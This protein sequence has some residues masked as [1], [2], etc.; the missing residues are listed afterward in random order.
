MKDL[1]YS[2]ASYTRAHSLKS[3]HTHIYRHTYTYTHI[4]IH[5]HIH[6]HTHIHTYTHTHSKTHIHTHAHTRHFQNHDLISQ[7]LFPSIRCTKVYK[8]Q[9]VDLGH[10]SGASSARP[11]ASRPALPDHHCAPTCSCARI[12]THTHTHTRT[13]THTHLTGD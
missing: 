9:N 10:C 1:H 5:T 13:H 4:H 2:V 11:D 8:L 6:V 7:S 3:T 12:H